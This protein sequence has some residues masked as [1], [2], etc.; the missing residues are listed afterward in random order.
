MFTGHT[1]TQGKIER[2]LSKKELSHQV[3]SCVYLY[4]SVQRVKLLALPHHKYIVGVR[5][6]R[7]RVYLQ[8]RKKPTFQFSTR[9]TVIDQKVSKILDDNR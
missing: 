2:R 6:C 3:C 4:P 1:R 9:K 8:Y 7:M 5:M